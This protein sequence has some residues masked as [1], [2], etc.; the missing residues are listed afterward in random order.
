MKILPDSYDE[1]AIVTNAEVAAFVLEKRLHKMSHLVGGGVID[2]G[3]APALARLV[4][5]HI[6]ASP[7]GLQS[8]EAVARLRAALLPFRISESE[9]AQIVNLRADTDA[10]LEMVLTAETAAR[11]SDHE[12]TEMRTLINETLEQRPDEETATAANGGNSRGR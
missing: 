12:W 2:R 11:L 10:T 9:F 6:K 1:H 7:A 3:E 8:V 4:L 5:R